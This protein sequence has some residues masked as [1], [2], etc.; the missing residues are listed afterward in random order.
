MRMVTEHIMDMAEHRMGRL[1]LRGVQGG[2]IG[3]VEQEMGMQNMK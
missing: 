3:M 2:R 1:P